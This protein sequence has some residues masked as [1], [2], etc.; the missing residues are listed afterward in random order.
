MGSVPASASL[1]L[2]RLVMGADARWDRKEAEYGK[3]GL[4]WVHSQGLT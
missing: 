1:L 2:F 4:N 3:I